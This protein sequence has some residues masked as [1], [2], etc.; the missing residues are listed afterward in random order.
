LHECLVVER[1][2]AQAQAL[3]RCKTTFGSHEAQTRIAVWRH[4]ALAPRNRPLRADRVA[5][6]NAKHE[7]AGQYGRQK[8]PQ[9]WKPERPQFHCSNSQHAPPQ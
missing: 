4:H 7:E 5:A 2:H 9:D 6:R 3:S 8:K 1:N